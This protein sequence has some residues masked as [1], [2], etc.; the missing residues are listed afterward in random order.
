M[1]SYE[2]RGDKWTVRFRVSKNGKLAN[3]RLSGFKTKKEAEHAYHNEILKQKETVETNLTVAELFEYFKD[4]KIKRVKE[5]TY[6]T[7]IQVLNDYILPYFGSTL[8]S[9]VNTQSI[10]KWQ[11]EIDKKPL[12][13][14]SKDKIYSTFITLMNFAVEFYNL[15]FNA[16]AKVGNFK[17]NEQKA[18]MQFWTN[19]EFEKFIA[20]VDDIVYKTFFATLYLT[21]ARKGEVMA[22]NWNDIDVNNSI[23]NITKTY[24]NKCIDGGYKLTTTKTKSSLRQIIIPDVLCGLLKKLKN[25]YTAFEGYKNE[26]F[27]FG[28]AKPIPTITL[29]RKKE[30]YCKLAGVK[31]IRYHDFRHSHASLLLNQEQNIMLVAQ[32]LGHSNISMTL[33]TYS[34]LFPNKQKELMDSLKIKI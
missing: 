5:S 30:Y 28:M 2:K 22:L 6:I 7:F 25:H 15:P 9:E 19:E 32:R 11:N 29:D 31:E 1:A 17:N 12:K 26:C 4:Y 20:I 21:G 27:V 33:N 8:I 34:H 24:S 13:F 23:I 18:K 16:V 10:M 3:L 14:R